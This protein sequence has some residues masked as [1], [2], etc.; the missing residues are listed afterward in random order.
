MTKTSPQPNPDFRPNPIRGLFLSEVIDQPTLDRLTP[1]LL[2]MNAE[3]RGPISLFI[4]SPGGSVYSATILYRLMQS[5]DQDGN[6]P[7]RLI[8]V[9]TGTAAS[10]AADLLM[11][12]DYAIA[13]PHARIL[14]HGVRQ[15]GQNEAL[16]HEKASQLARSLA[17]SNE[18]FAIQLAD[19][20][21]NRF[22]FRIAT[23]SK[24]FE[25]VRD[26]L[27]APE[28]PYSACFIDV[29]RGRIANVLIEV[30]EQAQKR[31]SDNDALDLAVSKALIGHDIMSMPQSQFEVL[32]LK[33][34]IEYEAQQ[35]ADDVDWSFRERGLEIIG[36]KLDLLLDKYSNHHRD[37]TAGLSDRWGGFF[38]SS[39]QENEIAMLP[40]DEKPAQIEKQLAQLS[41]LCGSFL[42]RYV[43][44]FN[45]MTT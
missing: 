10:A 26:R 17:N 28:M 16:T 33:T 37:M 39:Q 5:A 14:C 35:H 42:S 12:G 23:L 13:Y 41:G 25:G 40:D 30:L 19:N 4:D 22:I 15:G 27:N 8:T 44:R 6:S 7:C 18:R 11:A 2:R 3:S 31:S 9:V 1:A 43:A 38:L 34:I 29:L 45:G 36:D 20:C 32:L 24:E 21:I